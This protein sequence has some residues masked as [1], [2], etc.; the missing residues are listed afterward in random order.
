M[1]PC[2]HHCTLQYQ[3]THPWHL[4]TGAALP[5]PFP[6]T[7]SRRRPRRQR[8]GGVVAGRRPPCGSAGDG[9]SDSR[10]GRAAVQQVNRSAHFFTTTVSGA[11]G[12]EVGRPDQLM[13][14]HR[15][16]GKAKVPSTAILME[17][18]VSKPRK[19]GGWAQRYVVLTVAYLGTKLL[20]QNCCE[21]AYICSVADPVFDRASAGH[22]PGRIV[23]TH[24][25]LRDQSHSL[26]R[27]VANRAARDRGNHHLHGGTT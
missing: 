16:G 3:N 7:T 26:F 23:E 4:R 10:H 6:G 5:Q 27:W 14:G 9:G 1:P 2:P 22:F 11:C 15:I 13:W 17:G 19:E 25:I 20:L 24:R 21:S 18:V 12:R 8:V